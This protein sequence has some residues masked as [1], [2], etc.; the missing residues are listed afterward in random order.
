MICGTYGTL[1]TGSLSAAVDLRKRLTKEPP[2]LPR[3]ITFTAQEAL[4][5]K[6]GAGEGWL[7]LPLHACSPLLVASSGTVTVD[8]VEPR[9]WTALL[10]T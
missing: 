6:R 1:V 5:I 7:W 10:A 9:C 8:V 2:V 4:N 3:L